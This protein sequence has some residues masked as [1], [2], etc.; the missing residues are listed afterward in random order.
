MDSHISFPNKLLKVIIVTGVVTIVAVNPFIGLLVAKSIEEEMKKRKWGKIR[1]D[2]YY[3]KRRG[4]IEMGRNSDGSYQIRAT[5]K[6]KSWSQNKALDEVSIKIPKKWDGYWRLLIF[7]IPTEKYKAR[8][9]LLAKLKKLGFI[10]LQKS[11][12]AHP[13]ECKKEINVLV[14]AFGVERYVHQLACKEI[15]A[16]DFLR[17]EFEK[18]NNIK[19]I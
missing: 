6:G 12:W 16:G 13:F 4:F 19:L 8:F 2:L 1:K 17:L 18:I 7:D 3:L 10:M 5:T 14:K 9:A 11:V 15:S